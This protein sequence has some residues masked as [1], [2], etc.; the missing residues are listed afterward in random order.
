M[1][2]ID[3]RTCRSFS[4]ASVSGGQQ[5][6]NTTAVSLPQIYDNFVHF[7]YKIIQVSKKLVPEMS[8]N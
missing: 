1:F 6:N 7:S 2:T 3:W 8:T 5:A 4:L